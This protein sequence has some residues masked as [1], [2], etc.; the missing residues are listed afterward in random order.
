MYDRQEDSFNNIY[1]PAENFMGYGVNRLKFFYDMVR[2]GSS[3]DRIILSHI[4]LLPIGWFIKKLFPKK[5]IILL[6]HG[7]EVWDHFKTR[8]RKMLQ[9]CDIIL[10]VSSFTRMRVI[11]VHG[12][13]KENCTILNNCLDPFLHRHMLP[14]KDKNLMEK[15]DFKQNDLIL[16]TITRLS[17]KERYK[18]YDKVIEALSVIKE[19]YPEVKYLIAGRF[20]RQEKAYVDQLIKKLEMKSMVVIP[21]FIPDEELEAHFEMSDLYVMPSRKEGF[22]IV[23]IEAMYYGLP[24]IAGNADGST[25]ALLFGELG[26]LVNPLDLGEIAEAIVG[27]I[28]NKPAFTP[29][30]KLL[31][32]HFSYEVYKEKLAQAL[33]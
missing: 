26:K 30:Q 33:N 16:L 8:K 32:D 23:F 7:I 27:I 11:E 13:P 21:G 15:Y 24:V 14:K 2:R 9:Q 1:F 3:F 6:A 28:E 5:R 31:N 18:G 17:S 20:D 10:A 29:S 22:G 25:D 12:F 4:N 19:K